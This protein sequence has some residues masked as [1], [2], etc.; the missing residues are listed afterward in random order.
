MIDLL[1]FIA[2]RAP[3]LIGAAVACLVLYRF[4][5]RADKVVDVVVDGLAANAQRHALAYALAAGYA[6]LASLQALGEWATAMHWEL[7]AGACKVLQ[8]GLASLLAF[9]N[10]NGFAGKPPAPSP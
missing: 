4:R 9:A 3:F 5:V 6:T 1:Q 7:A 8:P 10:R 2:D